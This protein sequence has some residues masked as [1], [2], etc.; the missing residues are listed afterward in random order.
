MF[1]VNHIHL[2]SPDPKRTAQWYVDMFGAKVIGEGEGLGGSQTIR[3][4]I[5]GTR[6]NVTSAPAGETLPAGTSTSHYQVG[7]V[8]G[9][10]R[11]SES[12]DFYV[13]YLVNDNLALGSFLNFSRIDID[14]NLILD[15]IRR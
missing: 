8:T 14:S 4:D 1:R 2:K 13:H 6:F 10:D 9:L 12:I 5:E 15:P 11:W 3:L 7:G